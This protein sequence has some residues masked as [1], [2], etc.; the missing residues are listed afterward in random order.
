MLTSLRP[1]PNAT[2]SAA[3]HAQLR[4]DERQGAALVGARADDLQEAVAPQVALDV[5]HASRHDVATMAADVEE[6]NT[7]LSASRSKVGRKRV[8]TRLSVCAQ[9][10]RASVGS[11]TWMWSSMMQLYSTCGCSVPRIDDQRGRPPSAAGCGA[12]RGRPR[13]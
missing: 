10:Q 6:A 2:T 4:R 12:A 9:P 1:S 5:R 11:L 8:T 13:P 7:T 3:R